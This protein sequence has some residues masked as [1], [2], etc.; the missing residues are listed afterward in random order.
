[1]ARV[2]FYNRGFA[3]LF[4]TLIFPTIGMAES[5][6]TVTLNAVYSK[7]SAVNGFSL[8]V[9]QTCSS[10]VD[11]THNDSE[12]VPVKPGSF[13][14]A[15]KT[16]QCKKKAIGGRRHVTNAEIKFM[17]GNE[18]AFSCNFPISS[19]SA[20]VSESYTITL[21]NCDGDKFLSQFVEDKASWDLAQ[22]LSYS[23]D[24]LRKYAPSVGV[25]N[26][27]ELDLNPYIDTRPSKVENF[28]QYVGLYNKDGKLIKNSPTAAELHQEYSS[29]SSL[30]LKSIS[31]NSYTGEQD[32]SK[33]PHYAYVKT[34]GVKG[35]NSE[36][37]GFVD[38][39]YY[40]FYGLNNSQFFRVGSK[41][42]E[43]KNFMWDNFAFHEGDWEHITVRVDEN[44]MQVLGVF[45]SGHGDGIWLSASDVDF[46]DSTHVQAYSACNSHSS[47]PRQEITNEVPI[48]YG[49]NVGGLCGVWLKAIDDA[50]VS[51]VPWKP[52]KDGSII[53]IG[54]EDKEMH[55]PKSDQVWLT[56]KGHYGVPNF[57]TGPEKIIGQG[58]KTGKCLEGLASLLKNKLPDDY[59]HSSGPAAPPYQNS[60][61]DREE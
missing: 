58:G 23:A 9:R 51:S 43:H 21:W 33:A 38:I 16:A 47:N 52:W 60:W 46:E 41:F 39:Q 53:E 48:G 3:V 2:Y 32:L 37:A 44:F 24:I 26:A 25:C 8:M 18:K 12:S 59:L 56:Y 36:N 13:T 14:H 17:T 42:I 31:E 45:F 6:Y 49:I 10:G 57:P 1:M 20:S 35:K 28:L 61:N 7:V 4:L 30:Y 27:S 29:D 55:E 34:Y 15:F 40:F 11:Y 5:T 19:N 54:F 50:A 22:Q